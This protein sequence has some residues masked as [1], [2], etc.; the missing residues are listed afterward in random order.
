MPDKLE[1]KSHAER[2][3]I[4]RAQ[5]IGA[6]TAREL[7]RGELQTE[8]ER[9]SRTPFR[10]PGSDITKRYGVS[11]LERWYYAFRA[12]GIE[13]L[14]PGRTRKGFAQSLTQAQRDLILAIAKE[15][16]DT[17]VSVIV[18]ALRDRK[19]LDLV[20]VSDNTIRRFLASHGLDAA[21]R[22]QKAKGKARRRWEAEAPGVLWHADV[23]HGPSL[24]IDGRA[25]P[26]RIHGILDDASRCVLGLRAFHT[27]REVDMLSLFVDVLRQHGK[28]RTLYL[29]N[30][31]TY[32]GE[33]LSVA[34][35][36]LGIQLVHAQ[37]Y[38]P[39]AR[40]KMERFWRTARER[41]INH[42]GGL[43]SLHDVQ[44]RLLAFLDRHYLPMPH[45]S[46]FGRCP[47][48]V[49]STDR[50]AADP[51][52][53]EKLR[54]ALTTRATRRVRKDGTVAVG[55]IDWEVE[56]GYLAGRRVTIARSLFEP[57]AA[58]WIEQEDKVFRLRRLDPVANGLRP[59]RGAK[60]ARRGIDAIDFDPATAALDAHLGRETNR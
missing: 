45:A 44:A 31:S 32:R 52:P 18:Q 41:C 56:A 42:L 23:C 5:I 60:R 38:D 37:P 1:P 57:D 49:F 14:E 29:D 53:E 22:R 28:P 21:A 55:G 36:R 35:R 13:G 20:D 34:C 25:M 54:T 50:I 46:L 27:E 10:P 48:D 12:R 58:P 17:P 2:V 6:L 11:T 9:L 40:G 15:H 24:R 59:K 26:L 47:A 19:S 33:V 39:Q 8:L 16:S 3:A 51:V 30:G 4:F 43:G 7:E